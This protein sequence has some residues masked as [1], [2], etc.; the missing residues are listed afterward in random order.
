LPVDPRDLDL[1]ADHVAAAELV[2]GLRGAV[3]SDEARWDRGD[4]RAVRR[5]L[6]VVHGVEVEILEGVEALGPTGDAVVATPDLDHVDRII[7]SGRRIPVLPL[8]TM[9]IRF[10]A[11]G[12][13]ERAAMIAKVLSRQQETAE[14]LR[15][16]ASA[17]RSPASIPHITGSQD[18]TAISRGPECLRVRVHIMR[19]WRG[20]RHRRAYLGLPLGLQIVSTCGL[21]P[22][23]HQA[24]ITTATLKTWQAMVSGHRS[25]RADCP[26]DVPRC[27]I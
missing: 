11:T 21:A 19:S 3:V 17:A 1:L 9:Q 6:A 15:F 7:V 13:R 14:G 18:S 5:A 4:V 25:A 24:M 12:N 27:P 10:E 2:D 26:L 8:P 16:A 20:C 23:C 22:Q